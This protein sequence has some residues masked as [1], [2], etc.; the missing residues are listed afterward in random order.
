MISKGIKLFT[1]KFWMTYTEEIWLTVPLV[2][3]QQASKFKL[4]DQQR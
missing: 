2:T 4:N 1:E 3:C